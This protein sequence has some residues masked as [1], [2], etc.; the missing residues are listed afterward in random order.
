MPEKG[1]GVY[2]FI[3]EGMWVAHLSLSCH[4]H[5][6]F[7]YTSQ[8]CIYFSSFAASKAPQYLG[9]LTRVRTVVGISSRPKI[10]RS[11]HSIIVCMAAP[12][13][14]IIFIKKCDLLTGW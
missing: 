2:D 13:I 10:G 3:G 14:M 1:V 11:D 7:Q 4:T 6:P 8:F 5:D 9:T 12:K